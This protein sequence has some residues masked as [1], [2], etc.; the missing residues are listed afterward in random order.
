MCKNEPELENHKAESKLADSFWNLSNYI[1]TFAIAQWLAF[2]V[3]TYPG[4][5]VYARLH[6]P[7]TNSL[8]LKGIV[9]SLVFFAFSIEIC[10]E[11]ERRLRLAAHQPEV[12]R[13][14]SRWAAVGRTLWLA[15]FSGLLLWR[16]A[17]IDLSSHG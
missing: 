17:H 12:V 14:S 2:L 16:V 7:G 3:V 15:F 4:T 9:C 10:Y 8:A 5:E 13:N 11:R 6:E 1:T